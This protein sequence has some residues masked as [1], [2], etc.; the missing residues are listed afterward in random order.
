MRWCD[1]IFEAE[2]RLAKLPPSKRKTERHRTVRPLIEAFFSWVEEQ[3]A[4][5]RPR[6]LVSKALGYANRQKAPLCRFLEDGRLKITNNHSER[7]IRPIA[8]GR[9]AWL[10]FGS[11]DHAEAAA[12]LFSLIASCKLHGLDPELYLRDVIRV[13]P[14]WPRARYLE[15]APKYW[16]AT[17][18]R[19]DAHELARPVGIIT[20]P[21]P[22]TKQECSPD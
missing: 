12:N 2:G 3:R 21:S 18:A 14:Y 15:L 8:I 9:N 10:F 7:A 13:M 22:T 16:L 1:A 6:G 11:D 20:V 19:I 5:P 4:Q 17:R